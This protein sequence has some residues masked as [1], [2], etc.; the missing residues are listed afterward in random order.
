MRLINLWH[1]RKAFNL[2]LKR[3]LNW[4]TIEKEIAFYFIPRKLV[5]ISSL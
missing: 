1:R 2:F 3:S 4:F 5:D